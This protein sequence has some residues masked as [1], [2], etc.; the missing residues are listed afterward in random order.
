MTPRR[1][2]LTLIALT[3]ITALSWGSLGISVRAQ[4]SQGKISR[5]HDAEFGPSFEKP[6][7]L[8]LLG[9]DARGREGTDY[10]GQENP[11]RVRMDAIQ[12]LAIDPKTKRASL[13]GIPRDSWV[14]IPG[15]GPN[16][17]NA[18]GMVG[19]PELMLRTVENLSACRFDYYTLTSFKGFTRVVNDLG[20][21]PF[22]VD[23][24]LSDRFAKIDL[25]AGTQHF[26]GTK[27]LGWA[28]SRK[29]RPEGDF[30]RSREQGALMIAA[31]KEARAKAGSDVGVALRSL[32]TLRRNLKLN[33]PVDEA[34]RLGLLLLK[35]DPA[36]VSH[37][38]V[39]G[40]NDK[41]DG[42]AI[43]RISDRG[44]NQLVDI[45]DDGQLGS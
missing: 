5:A 24:A 35:I 31:L 12:I 19:G 28:R 18:A 22:H 42:T 9:G 45:C 2:G 8:L 37:I 32:A 23:K 17:I 33:I 7:F 3:A 41:V 29:T 10:G 20:G 21:F 34:F 30:D 38:V 36:D 14:D 44:R 39:D 43:V 16:K 1:F 27:A 26:D 13:V 6:I 4:P 40:F 25:P 11:E 15:R